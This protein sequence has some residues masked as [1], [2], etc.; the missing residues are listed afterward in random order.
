MGTVAITDKLK[1][2]IKNNV[3]K[4]FNEDYKARAK[5]SV[6]ESA[7]VYRSLLVT[8]RQTELMQELPPNWV[9]LSHTDNVRQQFYLAHSPTGQEAQNKLWLQLQLPPN[10]PFYYSY[11]WTYAPPGEH[12]SQIEQCHHSWLTFDL[13][14]TC[15]NLINR[16]PVKPLEE[17]LIQRNQTVGTVMKMLDGCKTLNQVEKIWP[18]IRKYVS[19]EVVQR[20]DHRPKRVT[21]ADTGIDQESLNALS[22]H[23]I[24]QQMTT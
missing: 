17:I 16:D 18:A 24:R 15:L 4:P 22:V 23:H 11:A 6:E 20:L 3:C 19:A 2:E 21:A 12:G 8:P 1:L 5:L 13:S 10:Q 14:T 9:N 7:A